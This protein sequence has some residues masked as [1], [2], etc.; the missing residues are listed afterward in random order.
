[1]RAVPL[2]LTLLLL[3]AVAAGAAVWLQGSV[4]VPPA[5]DA[6]EA[7]GDGQSPAVRT[8][9]ADADGRAPLDVGAAPAAQSPARPQPPDLADHVTA[10]LQVVD[11]ATGQP[12]P[13][14]AAYRFTTSDEAAIA[15]SD[16]K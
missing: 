1:M 3:L 12:V 9:A 5:P 10:W 8:A 2:V 15:Y 4:A 11:A 14:A 6:G 7:S 13:G 16:A